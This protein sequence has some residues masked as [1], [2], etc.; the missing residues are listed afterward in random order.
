MALRRAEERPLDALR[1]AD[2]AEQL[3]DRAVREAGLPAAVESAK[4]EFEN[5]RASLA[6]ATERHAAALAEVRGLPALAAE[7]LERGDVEPALAMIRRVDAHLIALERAANATARPLL[8]AAEEAVDD[9]VARG[10]AAGARAAELT[11]A[12]R[13]ELASEKPDWLELVARVERARRLIDGRR[14]RVPRTS[15]QCGRAPRR[16]RG[17][18]GLGAHGRPAGRARPRSRERGRPA[19]RRTRPTA[20]GRRATT[21]AQALYLQAA[22]A[23]EA[24][25][26]DAGRPPT[27]RQVGAGRTVAA[28]LK[29]LAARAR[30][31]RRCAS[32]MLTT[33]SGRMSRLPNLAQTP[34]SGRF[35]ARTIS[36]A[37]CSAGSDEAKRPARFAR[38][39]AQV[40]EH[41]DRFLGLERLVLHG[42]GRGGG[43]DRLGWRHRSH[44]SDDRSRR[45]DRGRLVVGRRRA[46]GRLDERNGRRLGLKFSSDSG[47][48]V[49]HRASFRRSS[50]R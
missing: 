12:A 22:A 41:R 33:A 28:R 26:E 19:A 16:T 24:A 36:A 49:V 50:L 23:A 4:R 15:T 2:E 5:A 20:P 47:P 45:R 43:L 27:L 21:R 35:S 3:A 34:G 40:Q 25:V 17:R 8:E 11:A 18:L 9:A 37:R 1:L 10:D 38:R 44:G 14:E 39:A 32:S 31:S 30:S 29:G 13:A 42:L 7:Q 46:H 48:E 6:A